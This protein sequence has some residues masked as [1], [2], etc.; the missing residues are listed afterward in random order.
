MVDLKCLK[1]DSPRSSCP[2]NPYSAADVAEEYGRNE[3]GWLPVNYGGFFIM[4]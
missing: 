1:G 4:L 3:Y 2:R